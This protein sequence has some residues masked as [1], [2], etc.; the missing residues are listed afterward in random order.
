MTTKA[1]L[2][3]LTVAAV[4]FTAS[5]LSVQAAGF[6]GSPQSAYAGG[7]GHTAGALPKPPPLRPFAGGVGHTAGALP[8]PSDCPHRGLPA[9]GHIQNPLGPL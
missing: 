9:C 7:V 6:R 5:V 2:T 3:A 1:T 8:M 4:T